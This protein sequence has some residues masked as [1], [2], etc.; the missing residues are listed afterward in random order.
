M[1]ICERDVVLV[2]GYLGRNPEGRVMDIDQWGFAHVLV[3]LI[4]AYRHVTTLVK[5]RTNG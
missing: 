2:I 4:V 5:V 1:I 3:G